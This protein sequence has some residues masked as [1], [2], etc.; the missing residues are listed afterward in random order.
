[1]RQGRA[2]VAAP[3]R[4]LEHRGKEKSGFEFPIA[5]TRI[6]PDAGIEYRQAGTLGYG[7]NPV[8]SRD[9]CEEKD[10]MGF[11]FRSLLRAGFCLLGATLAVAEAKAD[12]FHTVGVTAELRYVGLER[13]AKR[14]GVLRGK[15]RVR[16]DL[17]F[18]RL[19]LGGREYPIELQGLYVG[20]VSRR[21]SGSLELSG[22]SLLDLVRSCNRSPWRKASTREAVDEFISRQAQLGVFSS[23]HVVSFRS[24]PQLDFDQPDLTIHRIEFLE[25]G[26]SDVLV[27][28]LDFSDRAKSD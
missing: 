12:V 11:D 16:N 6:G 22:D 15:L 23:S 17:K 3:Q 9:T 4:S 20:R 25:E 27:L 14:M 21:V 19:E 7:P 13:G 8:V 28:S 5:R 18:S 2:F 1:M 26:N 24:L 10:K